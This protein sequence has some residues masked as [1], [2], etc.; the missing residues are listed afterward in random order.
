MFLTP[1]DMKMLTGFTHKAKQ[2]EYLKKEGI[3]YC[4]NACG[5]PVVSRS[6]IN[7]LYGTGEDDA[8]ERPDRLLADF[9]GVVPCKWFD[10]NVMD[11]IFT[12]K[13]VVN[14]SLEYSDNFDSQDASVYFLI[15]D[16]NVVY[17]GISNRPYE[18][19]RQHVRDGKL[20]SRVFLIKFPEMATPWL[21]EFYIHAFHPKLNDYYP[22]KSHCQKYL[23]MYESGHFNDS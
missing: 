7:K 22:P 1:D 2:V 18:R 17:V 12:Q 6:H 8:Q 23:D 19:L 9:G 4:L 21:E 14:N 16:S 20:F 15:N 3:T 5:K 13:H 11:Y 10:D